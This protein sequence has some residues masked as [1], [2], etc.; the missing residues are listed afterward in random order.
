MVQKLVLMAFIP[1]L[2][3]IVLYL[4]LQKRE[5]F[6]HPDIRTQIIVG[7]VFGL[8]AIMATEYSVPINGT[9][10]NVRDAA[11]LCAGLIFGPY[12]GIISGLIGGIERWFCV[13][14]GGGY[15]TRV[16]CTISTI[17]TGLISA[18]LRKFIFEDKVPDWALSI[19]SGAFC[20]T[21]HMVMIFVTN[22]ADA[23]TA[24][25]YILVCSPP[26]IIINSLA[27]GLSTLLI[28]M[29]ENDTR[30]KQELPTIS[31]RYQH[32]LIYIVI[33]GVLLTSAFTYFVQRQVAIMDSFETMLLNAADAYNDVM[34]QVER[35]HLRVTKEIGEDYFY[36]LTEKGVDWLAD[37]YGFAEIIICD[38]D[39]K[40][41]D[42]NV[43]G[44]IGKNIRLLR[45]LYDFRYIIHNDE[46]TQYV[47]YI[48]E[49]DY[50]ADFVRRYA[51][52]VYDDHIIITGYDREQFNTEVD[53][54]LET[55]IENRRIGDYGFVMIVDNN[56]LI[57]ADPSGHE[58]M[59][60]S[61]LELE[62]MDFSMSGKKRFSA[63]INNVD[64]YYMIEAAD[65]FS[66]Y[67]FMTQD[68]SNF[69][70]RISSTLNI[71]M[72]IIV[73]G[74]LFI[75]IYYVTRWII[76][77]NIDSV[78]DSL[79]RITNGDLDT[80]VEVKSLQEFLSLSDDINMTVDALKKFIK[81]ANERI[82]TEL[83]Y[84]KE[85][86]F[87][88][89]P[90][91]FPAFPDR[92]DNFDLYA[93]MDPAREVGGD[94]Y[95][96]YMIDS[97]TLVFLVADVSGKGIP[98][99]LF[100]MRAKTMIRNFA[101]AGLTPAN[102]LESANHHLCEG[103]DANMFVT[104]WIGFFDL[105]TGE[106]H[107]ANA[108]HNPPVIC[109]KDKEYEYLKMNKGFVLAA[110]DGMK[111]TEE[112]LTLM[113]GDAIFLYTDGVVEAT[114]VNK[115]LYGEG[116]LLACLNEHR[117]EDATDICCSVKKDVDD[118]YAGVDQFDDITELSLIFKSYYVKNK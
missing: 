67:A 89:L 37:Y 10:V 73:F 96:F 23:K 38:A 2:A 104:A 80:T 117:D 34:A 69:S 72:Q 65:Y 105:K 4:F 95:D 88:S 83:H 114:N 47:P 102:I 63:R 28:R 116:R 35:H 21:I 8:V 110:M 100:M 29:I 70:N 77:N 92:I 39:G 75:M 57:M 42:S 27:V 11:P 56:G 98:A 24:F 66:V 7:T 59:H 14:W 115:E 32:S 40:V 87:S 61:E 52:L 71:F 94:F 78:N 26:M 68:E 86:Q 36:D 108:G 25:S 53:R 9:M 13:Y 41:E 15:Y 82:D 84:A 76:V 97:H 79:D 113:P 12:A 101:E 17:L 106:L 20:E 5:L 58:G 55:V 22:S 109:R 81:E 3:S 48:Y 19:Y 16:A 103:N 51:G 118:F 6:D 49:Y 112:S 44:Y 33:V 45:N 50:R 91:S 111:Y 30:G 93:L 85:I 90:S 107:Y 62:D 74:L 43:K 54:R 64:Y 18:Y 31:A 60:V 1:V 46:M 99:S